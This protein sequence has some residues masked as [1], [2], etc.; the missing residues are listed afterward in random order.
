MVWDES[1]RIK[2]EMNGERAARQIKKTSPEKLACR[3]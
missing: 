1:G 2:E 3:I